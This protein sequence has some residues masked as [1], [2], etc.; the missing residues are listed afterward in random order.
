MA[1]G[2][3]GTSRQ[4]ST[5]HPS[6]FTAAS[7]FS[8]SPSPPKIIATPNGS[9]F[10]AIFAF[11]A[12]MTFLKNAWGILMRS[13]APSPVS[14]SFPVAPR[15]MSRVRIVMPFSTMSWLASPERLATI[16][17]PHASCSYSRL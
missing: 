5:S 17:T 3:V 14:G 1:S 13:P 4:P 12:A 8:S 7:I 15:C 16:P 11:F 10:F 6:P 9:P 2:F